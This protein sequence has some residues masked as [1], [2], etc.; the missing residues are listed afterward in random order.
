MSI[1]KHPLVR[2][3]TWTAIT[4]VLL[5]L[6]L[7][8]VISTFLATEGGSRQITR[9][10]IAQLEQLEG[11]S[12]S[13]GT[14]R[15]NLLQ[16]LQFQEIDVLT[17]D[18]QVRGNSV[19]ASW[20]PFSLLGGNLQLSELHLNTINV[21]LEDS[22]GSE[23]S[24]S[25][26][27][28]TFEFSALPIDISVASLVLEDLQVGSA[29][30]QIDIG[31]FSTRLDLSGQTLSL[32]DVV[33]AA[34]DIEL[35]GRVRLNLVANL[36][37]SAD[38]DWRYLVAVSEDLGTASGHVSVAGSVSELQ[39]QHQ[40]M[41]PFTI[42][43]RG[44]VMP[45]AADGV[46]MDLQHESDELSLNLGDQ[47]LQAADVSLSTAGT[48]DNLSLSLES[49]LSFASYP[50]GRLSATA[51]LQWQRITL[52]DAQLQTD[53][54]NLLASGSID[55]SDAFALR[56]DYQLSESDPAAWIAQELP[57]P[58]RD[59][60]GQGEF[61]LSQGNAGLDIRVAIDSATAVLDDYPLS[62]E[63]AVDITGDTITLEDLAL[64]ST[65]NTLT[66]SG[67]LGESLA[68][69]FS[70][71]APQLQQFLPGYQG[72]ARGTGNVRGTMDNPI[73]AAQVD[74]E[75][76]LSEQLQLE[77][78][79]LQIEGDPS[80]YAADL[81]LQNAQLA[82]TDS[83]I[84]IPAASLDFSGNRN[85][86]N[87]SLVIDSDPARLE[88][89]ID[90]GFLD[91]TGT[92]WRGQLQS[93]NLQSRVGQ[94]QLAAATNLSWLNQQAQVDNTCWTYADMRLCVNL[95][96]DDSGRYVANGNL[97][98]LPLGEFN[99]DSNREVLLA[100]SEIPR[101]PEGVALDG[102]A[103]INFH[104]EFGADQE[105]A[106]NFSASSDDA[107][108]TLLSS[109]VDEF[110]AA[111]TEDE[112]IAE[113]Y[114]WQ[115]VLLRGNYQRQEWDFN[116]RADL[117]SDN[118]QDSALE[119]SGNLEADL[120]LDSD[121]QLGGGVRAQFDNL[122]WVAAFI[123]DITDVSGSLDSTVNISGSLQSPQLSGELHLND[124]GLRVER[125]GTT[126]SNLELQLVSDN[127]DQASLTG[128][129]A[130]GEGTVSFSG[131]ARDL[132]NENW[133]LFGDLQGDNF[134]L[135]SLPDL[136]FDVSPDIAF[137]VNNQ[138]VE[139]T[140]SLHVP[141][142]DLTLRQLPE[143]AVDIS[144]DVVI[145]D[146]P[147]ERPELGM[148]F[149][150]GQTAIMDLPLSADVT[151]NL[152]EAVS[153]RGFGLD[154]RV[155]GEVD[156]QQHTSGTN[157]TYGEVTIAEGNYRI[158]GQRLDLEDGRLLFLGN[159]NNPALDIRAVREVENMT[160]GVL[161]HGTLKNIRSEL[162]STPDLPQN[163]ILAVLVTGRPYSDLQSTDGEAMIG[164]I[165]SL[166][167]EQGQ[168]LT[169]D[170]ADRF[171]LDSVA[172]TNTGNIDSST[173]TVGKYLTPEVF[174]R[175][176]VGLFDNSSKVAVD[177]M[178]NDRLTLQAESGEYQSIDLTYRVER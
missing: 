11:L 110:G 125:L 129:M 142:L 37:V 101:L 95:T 174:I 168:G 158:Y 72:N 146:Y 25:N 97:E 162:F 52:G 106:M 138:R 100:L 10:G 167:I 4:L 96:P 74:I 45:F 40:L 78:L 169:N 81:R 54:G 148:S 13:V 32:A 63:G 154:A 82:F 173:L 22:T 88:M 164:A 123:P 67:S 155:T 107:A 62:A 86:H 134:Q 15:G 150:T 79:H 44:R 85:S 111:V 43:S 159:Y 117:R 152:G 47:T 75:S 83:P 176:G 127:P 140:G 118:L 80:A 70:L 126:Y 105:P 163:E 135:A 98:G 131:T 84:A 38:L 114:H 91:S 137:D 147:A 122:G 6:L 19:S 65:A 9:W 8:T 39:I 34:Q 113:T 61:D 27:V 73:V 172:I 94:W 165:A 128:S 36:P 171:G 177:Y 143:S 55:W 57:A 21:V 139:L 58:L 24:G 2:Y 151:L 102:S 124:G 46:A 35:E 99:D 156:I 103:R 48:L 93:A 60:S 69:Q 23:S 166:G 119:L 30:Q 1:F 90:G 178:I 3:A 141:L 59:L 130:S 175:Y 50:P 49:A 116:A 14:I 26:P 89:R 68:L 53:T 5:L 29:G 17:P 121:S 133:H 120:T 71:D 77:S 153:F 20:N 41:T 136:V 104:A 42:N 157:L 31:R 132:N 18:L 149:T 76:L 64:R 7:L 160:V 28:A 51:R 33:F 87:A 109:A 115:R 12:I 145:V 170:I 16:G 144:R 112:I 161:M 108:L 92:D 56:L 66:L